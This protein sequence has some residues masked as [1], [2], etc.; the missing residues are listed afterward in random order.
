MR[1]GRFMVMNLSQN[2]TEF[3]HL[4]PVPIHE[5]TMD[6]RIE[7]IPPFRHK[8]LFWVIL[9]ALSM[10][11]AEVVSG[12]TMIPFDPWSLIVTTPLYT[13]HLL[14][15]AFIVFRYGKASF[16]ALYSAGTLFGM[17][18][19]YMTKVLW[20][21]SWGKAMFTLGGIAVFETVLLVLFWHSFMSFL[22]PIF[23]GE[24][25]LTA[26]TETLSLAPKRVQRIF[27]TRRSSL[28]VWIGLAVMFGMFQS[29]NSQ[30]PLHSLRSGISTATVILLLIGWFRFITRKE[31][32]EM[33]SLL[34]TPRQIGIIAI[35]L[36]MQY[37]LLGVL[38]RPEALPGLWPQL[39]VWL[40]YIS[41]ILLLVVHL[42][43]SRQMDCSDPISL[44]MRFS[45]ITLISLFLLFT[46]S[47]AVTKQLLGSRG[48]GI[49]L[50]L[51]VVCSLVGIFTLV[52]TIRAA[53][54]SPSRD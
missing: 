3:F 27:R 4:N 10:F 49:L 54:R 47:S 34:P 51:W 1:I 7:I 40:L 28:T 37:L 23:I 26:S 18:E 50:I 8:L 52:M 15:L 30:S 36:L 43:K 33:R 39:I 12:A 44:P 48:I 14:V 29:G 35:L 5:D 17:Y 24:N 21:P 2:Q 41:F 46:A 11:F 13:M 6:D 16:Y 32:Y 38:L 25:L 20:N 19:A 53:L 9:G 45:W 22:L 31:R 42:K